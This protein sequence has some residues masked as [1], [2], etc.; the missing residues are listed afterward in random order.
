MISY[1]RNTWLDIRELPLKVGRDRGAL[2]VI[3]LTLVPWL[4][5]IIRNP[6]IND[7]QQ[8]GG[9]CGFIAFY[10]LISH[11]QPA[12]PVPVKKPFFELAV[13]FVLITIW[14]L[15]RVGEYWHWYTLPTFGINACTGNGDIVVL[16]MAEM[17]VVPLLFLLAL[18]YSFPQLGLSWSKFAWLMALLPISALIALG[19]SHHPLE[20]FMTSTACY[21]F[22]AGLPEE[23]LFR[24]FLQTRLEAILHRPLWALWIASFI[25]GLTHIPIDLHGSFAHWPD[26][27]LTAFTFQ[28]SAGIAF[29]YAYMRT[30]NLLPVSIIHTLID[31][32]L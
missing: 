24:V 11:R 18:R 21:F 23:F 22:D 9:L 17:V 12:K 15:Y 28:M 10:W 1:L 14:I 2:S 5:L 16:K 3:I 7:L 32:A 26:A 29:G 20:Q 6:D 27:L 30:R 8:L 13:A 31:S 19:L 25:F 4:I